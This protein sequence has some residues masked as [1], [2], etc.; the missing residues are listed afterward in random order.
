[1]S[2][3]RVAKRSSR[4]SR[5]VGS[6]D[7]SVMIT[8]ARSL[9]LSCASSARSFSASQ[10]T[11][12]STL[13]RWMP[14]VRTVVAMLSNAAVVASTVHPLAIAAVT[15]LPAEAPT[16]FVVEASKRARGTHRRLSRSQTPR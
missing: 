15:K 11:S 2:S 8:A 12:S 6:D 1:M 3:C 13:Q 10:R 9:H 5:S 16:S 4:S 7:A 14:M